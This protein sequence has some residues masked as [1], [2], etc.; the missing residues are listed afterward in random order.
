MPFLA[1]TPPLDER[2]LT[3]KPDHVLLN[4]YSG[5]MGI[6]PHF[7]GPLYLERV[8]VLNL[9]SPAVMYFY[10]VS[11]NGLQEAFSLVLEPRSLLIFEGRLYSELKHGIVNATEDDLSAKSL[12]LNYRLLSS[13][14]RAL[15]DSGKP[16]S[17]GTLPRLS[18]TLRKIRFQASKSESEVVTPAEKEDLRRNEVNFYRNVSEL[19]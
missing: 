7:D 11:P 3:T 13:P 17:R 4:E 14:I 1:T 2:D 9:Q 5:G 16:L 18:L 6:A 12:P 15:L 19:N 10:H 8:L